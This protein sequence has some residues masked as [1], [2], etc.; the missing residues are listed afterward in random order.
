MKPIIILGDTGFIGSAF[1]RYLSESN[2]KLVAVNRRRILEV[3]NFKIREHPRLSQ[4]ISEDIQPFVSKSD[5]VIN[6][7]WGRNNRKDRDSEIHQQYA[8]AEIRLIESL[9]NTGCR[10]ISFGSIA[11]IN[12][13]KISPSHKSEYSTAKKEVASYLTSSKLM[14]LWLRIASVYGP[15]DNRDWFLTRLSSSLQTE[16]VIVLENPIQQINLCHIDSL[17]K[18]TL[19]LFE[20]K[21]SGTFNITTNQWITIG[22]LKQ[23]FSDLVEP[24]YQ[25]R[26]RGYFSQNDSE[27]LHVDTPPISDFF[28][29]LGNPQRS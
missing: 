21:V 23:C 15:G 28:R 6:T 26:L 16:E 18:T 10:Y 8:H 25:E 11:E 4:N 5:L 19:D 29:K 22:A 2:R 14:S 20:K 9:E 7:V 24:D 13:D 12:D 27:G 17:V 3:D 1:V